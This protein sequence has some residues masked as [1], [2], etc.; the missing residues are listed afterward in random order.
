[1]EADV[2]GA[3]DSVVEVIRD[4]HPM[5]VLVWAWYRVSGIDTANAITAKTLELVS[6][7]FGDGRTHRITLETEASSDLEAED[8]SFLH[9]TEATSHR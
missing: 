9:A 2:A 1:M 7:Y 4:G 3:P 8:R 5:P 6:R